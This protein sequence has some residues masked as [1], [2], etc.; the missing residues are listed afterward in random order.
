MQ[1]ESIAPLTLD[2]P[3]LRVERVQWGSSEEEGGVL[4][5]EATIATVPHHVFL[6]KVHGGREPGTVQKPVNDPFG[7]YEDFQKV[8]D[9]WMTPIRLPDFAGTFILGLVPFTEG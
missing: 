6:I 5:G 3:G 8:I 9:G 7:R 2:L 4:I 1:A